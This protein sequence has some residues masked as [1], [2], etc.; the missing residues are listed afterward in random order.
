MPTAQVRNASMQE[1]GSV[2][3]LSINDRNFGAEWYDAVG[4][5]SFIADQ[6]VPLGTTR[7][8][9]APEIYAMSGGVLTIA[10]AGLYFLHFCVTVSQSVTTEVIW[11]AFLQEDPDTGVFDYIPGTEGYN[12]FFAHRGT[13]QNTAFVQ[14]GQNYRYRI[15]ARR[16][17]G[18][19]S[20]TLVPV[21]S[22]LGVTCLFG[23]I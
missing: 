11:S 14:A 22:R 15:I 19:D 16:I 21:S 23:N 5:V 8:N 13:A 1:L 4:G 20:L 18:M 2:D 10:Q 17:G 3:H 9:S 7:H 6:V 12:T